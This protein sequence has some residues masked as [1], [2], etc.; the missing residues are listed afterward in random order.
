MANGFRHN[1]RTD[2][3]GSGD[4][5]FA[6]KPFQ[7]TLRTMFLVTFVVALCCSA[8]TTFDGI[9][10]FFAVSVIAW[11][12]VGVVYWK[13][14]AAAAVVF[15][16]VCGPLLGAMAWVG[17]AWRGSAWVRAWETLLAVGCIAGA[18]VSVG[19][20]LAIRRRRS[21]GG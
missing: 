2:A 18:M 10:L 17:S 20:A 14:R 19:I 1:M 16:H 11:G 4:D 8:T 21:R 5:P 7:F 3:T 6:R 15:A 9:M 13:I 12:V